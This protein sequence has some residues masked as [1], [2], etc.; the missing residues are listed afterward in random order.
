LQG[1]DHLSP[2]EAHDIYER[3]ARLLDMA[4]MSADEKALWRDLQTAFGNKAEHV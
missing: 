3:N 2:A 4:A 1:V